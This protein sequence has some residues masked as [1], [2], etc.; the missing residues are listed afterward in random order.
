MYSSGTIAIVA[1]FDPD[2]RIDECFKT[3]LHCVAQVCSRVIVVTTSSVPVGALADMAQVELIRRPNIG[4]DFMS[5]RI[6]LAHLGDAEGVNAIVLVNSSFVVVDD[7]AFIRTLRSMVEATVAHDVAG[8]TESRQ[9]Q[10]HLQSYLMAF[11]RRAFNAEWFRAFFD[12]VTPCNTKFELILKYELGLSRTFHSR[13][14]KATSL[15]KMTA[16]ERFRA[17]VR[18]LAFLCR[19][20]GVSIWATSLPYKQI[21]QFNPTHFAAEPLARRHGIVKKEVLQRNPHGLDTSIL[22][23]LL[24]PKY[25]AS[26]GRRTNCEHRPDGNGVDR[27]GRKQAGASGIDP[28]RMVTVGKSGRDGVR[29]AVVLHLYYLD[30][31]PE[32]C[33]NLQHIIEPFDLYVTTPFEADVLQILAA[34]RGL[35]NSTTVCLVENRGRD[36][37]PFL[38]LLRSGVLERYA[39]ALKIHGKKSLYSEKG[40]EWRNQIYQDLMGTSLVV[41][42]ALTLF[43]DPKVGLVGPLRC[44]LSHPRFWGANAPR[45]AQVLNAACGQGGRESVELGFYAGS[46]FWFRPAALAEVLRLPEELLAFED[47]GGQQDGTLAHAF[48]RAFALFARRSGFRATAIEIEGM[49]IFMHPA[50]EHRVPVLDQ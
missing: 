9:I 1:H 26:I 16:K 31:L 44:F 10:T 22:R 14:V 5:Y 36:I 41:R 29:L 30:L 50:S 46:M 48:E 43:E 27:T 34:T 19:E 39:V 42:R 17:C 6:G 8:L 24:G 3:L 38:M 45:L 21:G 33:K 49:D 23:R 28:R 7:A 40:D 12:D 35:A 32:I 11:S 37:R 2:D 20:H 15:F 13:A 47:E 18:W 25:G 4:Y